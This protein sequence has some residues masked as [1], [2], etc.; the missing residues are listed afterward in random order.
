M[1]GVARNRR[2]RGAR[3]VSGRADGILSIELAE[4]TARMEVNS[5]GVEMAC[6]VLRQPG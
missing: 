6:L 3:Q 2:R 5:W 1:K 4:E